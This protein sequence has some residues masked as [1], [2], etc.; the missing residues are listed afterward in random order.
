[1]LLGGAR[2]A[3]AVQSAREGAVITVGVALLSPL[4]HNLTAT[5][6]SDT[7]TACVAACLLLHLYL[8]D[9]AAGADVTRTIGGSLSLLAALFASV[10]LASRL[11]TP[12]HVFALM[13]FA[14][15]AFVAWPFLRRDLARASRPGQV[16]LAAAMHGGTVAALALRVSRLLAGV[17]AAAL[18]FITFVCPWSLVRCH[19]LK[20]RINGCAQGGASHAPLRRLTRRGA[21]AQAVGR[22]A[23]AAEAADQLSGRRPELL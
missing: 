14:L 20:R 8:H 19:K 18:L 2:L 23:A 1:V 16:L 21:C 3:A 10:L 17:H 6:S 11:P 7:I 5:I 4:F 13:M 22:G 9:Y 12:R 15:Q